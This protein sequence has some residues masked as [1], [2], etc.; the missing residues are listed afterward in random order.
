MIFFVLPALPRSKPTITVTY[1]EAGGADDAEG[2]DGEEPEIDGSISSGSHPEMVVQTRSRKEDSYRNPMF[3]MA[4]AEVEKAVAR[5]V[6]KTV[7]P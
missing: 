4:N 1:D 5:W 2:S 3:H 7:E 6:C